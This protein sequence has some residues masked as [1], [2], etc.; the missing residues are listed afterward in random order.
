MPLVLM[1]GDIDTIFKITQ[2]VLNFYMK[3]LIK[4]IKY[5]Y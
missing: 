5:N 4:M 1:N 2:K 3:S